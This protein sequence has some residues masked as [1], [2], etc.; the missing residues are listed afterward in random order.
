MIEIKKE[1]KK[2]KERLKNNEYRRKL[3]KIKY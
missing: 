1:V 2:L 3:K